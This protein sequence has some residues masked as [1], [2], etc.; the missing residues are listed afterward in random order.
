IH[1][2]KRITGHFNL[3]IGGAVVKMY[4]AIE[5]EL[6]PHLTRRAL[7]SLRLV[8]AQLWLW[9]IGMIVATFPSHYVVILGMPLRMAYY[10]YSD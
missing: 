7:G 2:T 10:D 1:N 6:W 5:Y 9:Y 3:I 8:K 4:F